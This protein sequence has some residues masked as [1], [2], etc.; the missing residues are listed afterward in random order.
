MATGRGVFSRQRLE[1]G[2]HARIRAIKPRALSAWLSYEFTSQSGGLRRS[3]HELQA[4]RQLEDPAATGEMI[5]RT[6]ISHCRRCESRIA[7]GNWHL[8]LVNKHEKVDGSGTVDT[9]NG[10][11]GGVNEG[12]YDEIGVWARVSF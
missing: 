5:S 8:A 10:I 4:Q 11:I 7:D 2:H 1:S 12:T 6:S 9:A 3:A